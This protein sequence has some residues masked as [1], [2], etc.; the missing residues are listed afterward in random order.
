MVQSPS[1]GTPSL[2]ARALPNNRHLVLEYRSAMRERPA[3]AATLCDFRSLDGYFYL[4]FAGN[5]E[6]KPYLG[7]GWN[8]LGLSRARDLVKWYP[9]GILE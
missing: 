8:R 7:R 6:G 3:I 4:L 1:S 9:A 5:T 2:A